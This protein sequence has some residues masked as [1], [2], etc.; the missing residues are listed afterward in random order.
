[1]G[2]EG[3]MVQQEDFG[4][5][6]QRWG[7][8]GT[9]SPMIAPPSRSVPD[10]LQILPMVKFY[11]PEDNLQPLSGL[12]LH[13]ACQGLLESLPM[14]WEDPSQPGCSWGGSALPGR[15]YRVSSGGRPKV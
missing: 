15:L 2:F 5:S 12:A 11:F 14:L 3:L 13:R 7:R 1:M 8:G 4:V 9:D 10:D 6:W